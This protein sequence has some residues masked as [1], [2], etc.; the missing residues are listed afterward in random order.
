[1]VLLHRKQLPN[2]LIVR[3]RQQIGLRV[4]KIKC[5]RIV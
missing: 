1:M 3:L 4:S 2:T 5:V